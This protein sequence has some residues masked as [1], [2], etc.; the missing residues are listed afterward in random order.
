MPF[1]HMPDRLA[2]PG[3]PRRRF[4]VLALCGHPCGREADSL[5]WLPAKSWILL[6]GA[7]RFELPTPCAQG[8]CA[9]RLRYAPTCPMVAPTPGWCALDASRQ[10]YAG[11]EAIRCSRAAL[12]SHPSSTITASTYIHTSS[13]K[14]APT[15]P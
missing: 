10:Y 8:R 6:V 12:N 1:R 2:C 9:T 4:S 15:L 13:A 14:P 7:G 3:G 5:N 11:R